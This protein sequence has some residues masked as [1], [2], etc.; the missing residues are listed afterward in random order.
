VVDKVQM[1][2]GRWIGLVLY[3]S[4]ALHSI[5]PKVPTLLVGSQ[6]FFLLSGK[7]H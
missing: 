4:P 6:P 7:G 2:P 5:L 1:R 3:L